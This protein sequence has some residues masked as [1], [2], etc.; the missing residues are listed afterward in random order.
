MEREKTFILH[1]R[2]KKSLLTNAVS[3]LFLPS[4]VSNYASTFFSIANLPR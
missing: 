4:I 3:R 2:I 1:C